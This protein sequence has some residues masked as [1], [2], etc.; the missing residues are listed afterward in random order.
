MSECCWC[1]NFIFIT[2]ITNRSI[3]VL[4]GLKKHKLHVFWMTIYMW[5]TF[6]WWNVTE[7]KSYCFNRIS[8]SLDN[9]DDTLLSSFNPWGISR[10]SWNMRSALWCNSRVMFFVLFCFKHISLNDSKGS[11]ASSANLL[12]PLLK[13]HNMSSKLKKMI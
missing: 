5:N 11:E 8:S 9:G 12:V 2:S 1:I 6:Y 7:N 10:F 13:Y 3:R 4:Y